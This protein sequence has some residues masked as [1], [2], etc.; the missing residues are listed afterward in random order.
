MAKG[1]GNGK[2]FKV[3][4]VNV[5]QRLDKALWKLVKLGIYPSRSEAVRD[6]IKEGLIM[7]LKE[8][9]LIEDFT[10]GEEKKKEKP[11]IGKGKLWIDGKTVRI[12]GVG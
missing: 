2:T 8:L 7:K 5:N 9:Q 4:T 10:V 11:Y 12:L 6:F 1:S 3:I